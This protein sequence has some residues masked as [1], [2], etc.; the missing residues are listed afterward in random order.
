MR[1]CLVGG[2]SSAD[3][4]AAAAVA[5]AADEASVARVCF[6]DRAS[7][8]GSTSLLQVGGGEGAANAAAGA[9]AEDEFVAAP[10]GAADGYVTASEGDLEPATA[11]AA[12]LT[13]AEAEITAIKEQGRSDAGYRWSTSVI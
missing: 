8:C 2:G 3:A 9:P 5:P 12:D 1:C 7:L 10:E 11:G 4:A 6:Q 13:A